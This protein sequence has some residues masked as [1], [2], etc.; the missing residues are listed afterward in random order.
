VELRS[1]V[2]KHLDH[3]ER[4][5]DERLG[6]LLAEDL[7]LRAHFGL[8]GQDVGELLASAGVGLLFLPS[9]ALAYWRAGRAV[10]RTLLDFALLL[11]VLVFFAVGVDMLHSIVG[12][13]GF[14]YQSFGVLED[15]GEL[16]TLSL[17]V[18]Y[19]F[20]NAALDAPA[21]RYLL[22]CLRRPRS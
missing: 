10:R 1:L 2:D 3:G 9:L 7:G 8:R 16:V 12:P 20:L 15:G 4:S 18:W 13:R 11:A 21:E 5:G 19:A 6:F 14:W 22:D 17:L